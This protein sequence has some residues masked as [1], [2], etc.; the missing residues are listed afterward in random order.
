MSN[1]R[2]P[3]K[4]YYLRI[5]NGMG[6]SAERVRMVYA[7]TGRPYVDVLCSFAEAQAAAAG[8][9]PFKQFP[10]IETPSGQHIYQSLAIMHH[11]AHGT[12]V[13]PSDP[14]ALTRALAV[15]LGAYDFYMSFA[16]FS[17]TDEIAKK[18]FEDRRAPQYLGALGEIYASRKFAAGDTP[19]FADCYAYGAISWVVRRNEVGKALF[20]KNQALVDFSERFTAIPAISDFMAKQRAAREVDPSV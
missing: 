10:F 5:P 20:E 13:W 19:T 15:A 4:L 8:K 11:V 6:G 2:A 9:N 3:D 16:G 12:S 17:A 14:E 1:E 18:K 7:L